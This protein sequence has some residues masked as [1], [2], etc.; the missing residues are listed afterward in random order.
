MAHPYFALS[1]LGGRIRR[2]M[3]MTRSFPCLLL[4]EKEVGP[5]PLPD[6]ASPGLSWPH[7]V[8][9][10]LSWL[11]W[12]LLA[13]PGFIFIW[14]H[15]ASYIWPH[16][17]HVALCGSLCFHTAQYGPGPKGLANM[18]LRSHS[19]PTSRAFPCTGSR[20]RLR[21]TRSMQRS[22]QAWATQ[23]SRVP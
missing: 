13:F 4:I 1:L 22:V 14:P 9:P 16:M 21:A 15:L 19:S 23:R 17:A 11:S 10:G 20:M 2:I 12:P 5:L 18:R 7:L 8:S 3:A 6:L